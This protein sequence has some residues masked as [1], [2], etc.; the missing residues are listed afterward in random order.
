MAVS[1]NSEVCVALFETTTTIM[2]DRYLISINVEGHDVQI[3]VPDIPTA[4]L[5][6]NGK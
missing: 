5:L 2:T 4:N 3:E 1:Y 6:L